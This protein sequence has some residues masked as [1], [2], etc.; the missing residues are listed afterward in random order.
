MAVIKL[1][2]TRLEATDVPVIQAIAWRVMGE[3]VMV[4]PVYSIPIRCPQEI[5]DCSIVCIDI[6][7]CTEGSD[8][9]AQTC[10]N[11]VGS[12]TCSCLSGYRLASDRRGCADINECVEGTDGCSQNCTNAIGSYTCSCNSGYRLAS[13]MQTCNGKFH[14]GMLATYAQVFLESVMQIT[15]LRDFV[16]EYLHL[17][18]RE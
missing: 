12:Y 6:N 11:Q 9:C 8:G 5:C 16:L 18:K 15:L 7:E 4:S 13:D 10:S 3:H 17:K 14:Q 1:V 2:Q